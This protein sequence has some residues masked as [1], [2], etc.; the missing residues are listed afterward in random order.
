MNAN[1]IYGVSN[2]DSGYGSNYATDLANSVVYGAYGVGSGA[3][4]GGSSSSSG[5]SNQASTPESSIPSGGLVNPAHY[6]STQQQAPDPRTPP[7]TPHDQLDA[8]GNGLSYTNLDANG[9][10]TAAAAAAAAAYQHLNPHAMG[11]HSLSSASNSSAY[12]TEYSSG[13]HQQQSQHHQAAHHQSA[14]GQQHHGQVPHHQ[15]HHGHHHHAHHHQVHMGHV[16]AGG[17]NGLSA[18]AIPTGATPGYGYPD[19]TQY[20]ARTASGHFSGPYGVGGGAL[21]DQCQ[22]NGMLNLLGAQHPGQ[23]H[24]SASASGANQTQQHPV[25]QQQQQQ[26]QQQ[27]NMPTYKWMQVKRNVPK[28]GK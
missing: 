13:Q 8:A 15:A 22:V 2:M 20:G 7:L 4:S 9:Y 12:Q 26:Q 28:P 1:V 18:M 17:L 25:Q 21:R 14:L 27:S 3:N 11:Q 19:V 16:D 5:G 23:H 10:A 24:A 6:L